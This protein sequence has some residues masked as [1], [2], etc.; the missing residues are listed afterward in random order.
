[1]RTRPRPSRKPASPTRWSFS[2]S[3]SG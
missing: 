3:S 2:R 1:L